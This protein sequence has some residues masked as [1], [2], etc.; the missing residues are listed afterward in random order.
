[1]RY[2]IVDEAV[3]PEMSKPEHLFRWSGDGLPDVRKALA[4][5]WAKNFNDK[6][7]HKERTYGTK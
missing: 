1:L 6:Q 4:D 5:Q 3:L 2:G 7:G